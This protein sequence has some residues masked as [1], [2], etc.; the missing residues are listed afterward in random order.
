MA[1][2]RCNRCGH[3]FVE[4]PNAPLQCPECYSAA[5][6]IESLAVASAPRERRLLVI[7]CAL[8]SQTVR[9]E[10]PWG[11]RAVIGREAHGAEQLTQ[12][13]SISRKHFQIAF[14]GER[15]FLEDVGSSQGTYVSGRRLRAGVDRLALIDGIQFQMP[16]RRPGSTQDFN[17]SIV[18]AEPDTPAPTAP[19]SE[20][21][22]SPPQRCCVNCGTE[23]KTTGPCEVCGLI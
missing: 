21:E 15:A 6:V 22:P 4:L 11:E 14:D 1:R 7:W 9:I 13:D 12:F 17:V 19:A 16:G 20:R 5:T 8:G 18:G 23:R 2:A 10:V 3:E